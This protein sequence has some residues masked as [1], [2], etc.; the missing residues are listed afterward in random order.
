MKQDI[1]SNYTL[2]VGMAAASTSAGNVEG[3]AVDHAAAPS[4]A[5]HINFGTIGSS[6]TVDA[7]V[8]HSPDNSTW[9]DDDGASGNDTAITQITAAGGATLKVPNPQARYSRC[10]VTVAVATC[11][12]GVTNISGPLRHIAAA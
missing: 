4:C 12:G 1:G 3:A 7:K 8:Q 2:A 9:T 11:V 5:F 6:G 10:Y